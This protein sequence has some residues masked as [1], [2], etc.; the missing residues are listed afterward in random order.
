MNRIPMANEISV[1]T[2]ADMERQRRVDS[3]RAARMISDRKAKE[4][5]RERARIAAERE[6][7][8]AE[9]DAYREQARAALL[10]SG[11]TS[12]DFEREWPTLK[13]EYLRRRATERMTAK[14]RRVAEIKDRMRAAGG[15]PRF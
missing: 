12:A 7:G 10:A 15:V 9:L 14:E 11:G 13:G 6:Q 5:E 2:P 8:A 1:L 4:A 3:E